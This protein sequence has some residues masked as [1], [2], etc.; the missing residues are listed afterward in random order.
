MVR[1]GS[2]KPLF[3]G[4]NPVDASKKQTQ[5][6]ESVFL[7]EDKPLHSRLKID[8][9]HQYYLHN[10]FLFKRIKGSEIRIRYKSKKEAMNFIATHFESISLAQIYV[11][12]LAKFQHVEMVHRHV[13]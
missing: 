8:S 3:T 13:L 7:F 4:S 1:Q 9:A 5:I 11:C 10:K 6:T 12:Q 2:A